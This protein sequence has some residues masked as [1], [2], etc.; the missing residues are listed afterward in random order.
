MSSAYLEFHSSAR[1]VRSISN[2][3]L[4]VTAACMSGLC[5]AR[6]QEI[7]AAPACQLVQA[8]PKVKVNLPL[9]LTVAPDGSRRNF[10]VQQR[11]KILLLPQDEAAA[12]AKVFL[13]LSGR[14]MEASDGAFEEGLIGMA[15]HPDFARNRKFFVCYTQQDPKRSVVSEFQCDA[16]NPDKADE[17]TERVILEMPLPYWNHHSGNLLF[18]PDGFL[19]ITVGDGG[20]RD[21]ATRGAQ[22]LF[23]LLGKMLRIDVNSKQ[24]ARQYAIPADNPFAKTPGARPEVYAWGLRN[25]WGIHFDAEGALWCADVGQDLWEEINLIEKGGNYG[26]SFREGMQK[27]PLRTDAPPEDAKLVDPIHVY[28]RNDGLS[29][30]GGV[31]YRGEKIPA[32]KGAYVYGDWAFGHI[33]ALRY[34]KAARKVVSNTVIVRGNTD[35]NAKDMVKPSAICED[36]AGE[37]CVLDWNHRIFRLAP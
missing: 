13:D 30:T 5:P 26:W 3:L 10:V 11:G 19:Y 15:F 9:A 29:I 16:A 14:K 18:G 4:A 21:D 2:L 33:W 34:D 31:V 8:W 1:V 23:M 28:T 17:S 25:P 35:P 22:N 27:F 7:A 37:I 12:E 36:A 24:G 32:L 6:A 20:K